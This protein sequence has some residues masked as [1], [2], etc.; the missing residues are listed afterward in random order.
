MYNHSRKKRKLIKAVAAL[1]CQAVEFSCY[2]RVHYVGW[3]WEIEILRKK[4]MCEG[5]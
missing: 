2:I 3:G 5:R 1:N 4:L